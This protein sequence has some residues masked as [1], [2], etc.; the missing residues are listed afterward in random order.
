MWGWTQLAKP[1]MDA[2]W[3][4]WLRGAE[5]HGGTET[6][7]GECERP[8]A[9]NRALVPPILAGI[10]AVGRLRLG[11]TL[12]LRL[13]VCPWRFAN[14][15]SAAAKSDMPVL[16]DLNNVFIARTHAG[17]EISQ[18]CRQWPPKPYLFDTSFVCHDNEVQ[19][20]AQAILNTYDLIFRLGLLQVPDPAAGQL[21]ISA[22]HQIA[23]GNLT[24]AQCGKTC[25]IPLGECG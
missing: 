11:R 8:W 10:P 20:G 3:R 13:H 16:K 1:R 15:M 12:R 18:A 21:L 2:D 25:L 4:G 14:R 22:A 17:L 9:P 5:N 24:P 6:G 23:E 7:S 19:K